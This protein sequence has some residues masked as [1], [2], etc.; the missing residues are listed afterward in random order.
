M[1]GKMSERPERQSS[2]YGYPYEELSLENWGHVEII[3]RQC[4]G[5]RW[6]YHQLE[7]KTAAWA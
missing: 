6:C 5:R 4:G 7:L 1:D 3:E 2:K